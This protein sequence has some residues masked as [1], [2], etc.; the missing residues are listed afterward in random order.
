MSLSEKVEKFECEDEQAT[1]RV[2]SGLAHSLVAGDV[3]ALKGDLGAGKTTFARYVA[4]EL[5]FDGIVSSPTFTLFNIYDGEKLPIY[6]FDFYRLAN[7]DEAM[8]IGADEYLAGAG[9]SLVEWP[10]R[11]EELIPEGAI[12]VTLKIPDFHASPEKREIQIKMVS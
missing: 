12:E 7:A 6:H 3:I 10:E 5:G 1:R 8:G 4:R 2:A 11:G 9:V